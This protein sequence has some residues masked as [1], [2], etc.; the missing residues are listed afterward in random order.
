MRAAVTVVVHS[1]EECSATQLMATRNCKP[2]WQCYNRA[3][4]NRCIRL[5]C[6]WG[7]RCFDTIWIK[8]PTRCHSWYY[9]YFSF[10]GCSTCFG[11]P[12]A[13]LQEL[14]NCSYLSDVLQSRGCVGSQIRLV[15]C[16]SIGKHLSVLSASQWTDK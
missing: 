14:T 11:P 8:R 3:P 2:G 5:S 1:D 13:H 15:A 9:V 10:I 7:R 16:L 4:S 12:C 6:Q